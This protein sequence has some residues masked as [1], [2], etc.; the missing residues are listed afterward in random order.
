MIYDWT[1][2]ALLNKIIWLAVP[3]C[4]ACIESQSSIE[5]TAFDLRMNELQDQSGLYDNKL[6]TDV[7]ELPVTGSANFSGML[8]I[9]LAND[10]DS[11]PD[12]MIATLDLEVGFSPTQLDADGRA[13]DFLDEN[14]NEINGELGIFGGELNRLGDPSVDATV[15][16]SGAG[17]LS[18]ST[19]NEIEIIT[20]FEGDFYGQDHQALAG[21]ALGQASSS[22][23][24]QAIS[25]YFI[26]EQ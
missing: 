1:L 12:S 15:G 5:P 22:G 21:A 19:G 6:F 20:I 16:F 10:T 13:Y 3:F 2:S 9:R 23:N 14:S 25:G 4:T 26:V 24:N 7:A 17:T 8:F 18:D 11:L